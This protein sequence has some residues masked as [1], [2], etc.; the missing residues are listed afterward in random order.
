MSDE[1]DALMRKWRMTLDFVRWPRPHWEAYA[2]DYGEAAEGRTP[3]S[4]ARRLA[5]QLEKEKQK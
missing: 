3:L 1:L 5:R 4:A 2:S